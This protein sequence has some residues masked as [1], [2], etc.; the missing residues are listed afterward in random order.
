M[1]ATLE[2]SIKLFCSGVL[3]IQI[4]IFE[5]IASLVSIESLIQNEVLLSK[6]STSFTRT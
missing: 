1:L 5:T 4:A 6:T 2:R 3:L